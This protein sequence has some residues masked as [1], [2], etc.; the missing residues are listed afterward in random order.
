[1]PNFNLADYV[2]VAERI[3]AFY[4]RFPEG[5]LRSEIVFDDGKRVVVK[6]TAHRTPED[7]A[8]ATGHA[9]EV[10]GEGMVNKTSALENAETSA[11]GRAIAML[12]FALSKGIAS[13]EEMQQAQDEAQRQEHGNK[14]SRAEEFRNLV[15]VT[16]LVDEAG[17]KLTSMNVERLDDLTEEQA[18]E[19]ERWL[20]D[21]IGQRTM[22]A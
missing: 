17:M 9:E 5:S 11:T 20:D 1:M 16:G 3:T 10:R 6:A 22:A 14:N 15:R 19:F 12:G 8:P 21:T 4:E 18:T 13:R 2:T 7:L